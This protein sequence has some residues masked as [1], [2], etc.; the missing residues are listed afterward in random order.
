M[1]MLSQLFS[2]MFM[3][4]I[5]TVFFVYVNVYV[6]LLWKYNLFMQCLKLT[7]ASNMSDDFI[8]CYIIL[9]W[10]Y[11]WIIQIILPLI[12]TLHPKENCFYSDIHAFNDSSI[13]QNC[14]PLRF[15]SL[16]KK[17][18]LNMCMIGLFDFNLF[19]CFIKSN[20]YLTKIHV[21][22]RMLLTKFDVY[23]L[24]VFGPGV[25]DSWGVFHKT[26]HQWQMTVVV[27]SYWNPCFWLVITN[28]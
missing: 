12:F 26:C 16:K 1:E 23:L 10:A 17:I 20:V 22:T 13:L 18:I 8:N 4:L 27:I 9:S 2:Y 24:A 15:L 28:Q 21:C 14:L 19:L 11:S 6:Y 7:N 5:S 3:Y 25:L